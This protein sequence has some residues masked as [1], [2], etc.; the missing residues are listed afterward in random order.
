[1][2][3]YTPDILRQFQAIH[4]TPL[5]ERKHRYGVSTG[6]EC[7]RFRSGKVVGS[8]FLIDAEVYLRVV[9]ADTSAGLLENNA[10]GFPLEYS[11][12]RY[13]T[14]PRHNYKPTLSTQVT[15][16]NH[17]Y[18]YRV[19]DFGRICERLVSEYHLPEDTL[20]DFTEA[21]YRRDGSYH[22]RI[23]LIVARLTHESE[24]LYHI[25]QILDLL[26]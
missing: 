7:D 14:V 2:A 1:M 6:G 9:S 15:L 21:T 19:P 17:T 4:T 23:V 11:V 22:N 18:L 24:R 13:N 8:Y 20:F 5:S 10:L 16:N 25:D 26:E 12:R 3:F